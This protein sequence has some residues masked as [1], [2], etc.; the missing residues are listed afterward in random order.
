MAWIVLAAVLIKPM[1]NFK[2]E[3]CGRCLPLVC[4]V[5]LGMI[6]WRA[7]KI[8][9]H[10][11]VIF[12]ALWGVF[13]LVL[14]AKLGFYSRIWHYGFVLAMPASLTAIYFLLRLL[15]YA[16]EKIG[17][18]AQIWRSF[19]GVFLAI[20]LMQL[21]LGSKFTYQKKT[22]PVASGADRL[23]AYSTNVD[24]A[25]SVRVAET[26]TWMQAHTPANTTVAALPAG[27]MLNFL[28][29][30]DNPNGYLRWNP[31]EL[32]AFGQTNM[33]RAFEERP[34]DYILLL[35]LDNGEF[36]D[37]LAWRQAGDA[38][39]ELI[40]WIHGHYHQIGLFMGSDWEQTDYFGVKIFERDNPVVASSS[41][42]IK[43]LNLPENPRCFESR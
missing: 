9:W 25:T 11:F 27:A 4:L 33:N 31:A 24:D 32:A 8:G 3:E 15:P 34:P 2:W 35:G 18:S 40:A 21:M 22:V 10:P 39:Q 42:R 23:W 6:F 30:R 12:G 43:D 14:M 29:R 16:L 36:W 19:V 37:P 41:K 5:M 28:L 17:V 13:S 7:R 38:A 1:L 26:F 20:A